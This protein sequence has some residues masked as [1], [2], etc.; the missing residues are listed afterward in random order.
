MHAGILAAGDLSTA[1][2]GAAWIGQVRDQLPPDLYSLLSELAVEPFRRRSEVNA[3]YAGQILAALLTRV[4]EARLR[5]LHGELRRAE[6]D[7]DTELRD[8]LADSIAQWE[9]YRRQLRERAG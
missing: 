1:M 2:P 5:E 8:K 3:E 9:R 6:A 7:G 4:A